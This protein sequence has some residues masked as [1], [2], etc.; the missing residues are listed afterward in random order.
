MYHASG[1]LFRR[2]ATNVWLLLWL[3]SWDQKLCIMCRYACYMGFSLLIYASSE[4]QPEK[5]QEKQKQSRAKT[6]VRKSKKKKKKG[7]GK[8][9]CYKVGVSCVLLACL[10][11][12]SKCLLYLYKFVI[13]ILSIYRTSLCIKHFSKNC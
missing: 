3:T 7:V 6:R 11:K 2:P 1:F 10:E 8:Y 12:K 13:V 9:A 4:R 5:I